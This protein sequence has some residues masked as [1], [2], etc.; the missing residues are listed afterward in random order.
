MEWANE[1]GVDFARVSAGRRWDGR[2]EADTAWGAGHG[3]GEGYLVHKPILLFE[4]LA[5]VGE[6]LLHVSE[7]PS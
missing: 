2:G 1:R 4:L 6:L 3:G 7:F 5:E